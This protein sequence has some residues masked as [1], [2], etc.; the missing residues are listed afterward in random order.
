MQVKSTDWEKFDRS[1]VSVDYVELTK[2]TSTSLINPTETD[3]I[4]INPSEI[5]NIIFNHDCDTADS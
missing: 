3:G 1:D 4:Q 2:K 5:E